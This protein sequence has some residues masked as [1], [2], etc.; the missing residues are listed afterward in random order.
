[1][2]QICIFD[3]R[4]YGYYLSNNSIGFITFYTPL[5]SLEPKLLP[6]DHLHVVMSTYCLVLVVTVVQVAPLV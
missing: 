5:L 2:Q 3:N 1:M 6:L 4:S